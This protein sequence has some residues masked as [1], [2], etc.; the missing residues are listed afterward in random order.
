MPA[1]CASQTP[2]CHRWPSLPHSHPHAAPSHIAARLSLCPTAHNRNEGTS[3]LELSYK[4][5]HIFI[6]IPFSQCL[7]LFTPG[8]PAATSEKNWSLLPTATWVSLEAETPALGHTSDDCIP[9]WQLDCHLMRDSEPQPP[10]CQAATDDFAFGNRMDV[11]DEFEGYIG[12]ERGHKLKS[13]SHS[14]QTEDENSL[15]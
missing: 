6:W 3:L 8:K 9:S 2:R 7:G 1:P 15:N 5:H 14:Y 12:Q 10:R 11:K 4:R 13:W